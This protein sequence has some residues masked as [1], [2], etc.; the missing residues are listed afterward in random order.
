MTDFEIYFAEINYSFPMI[1]VK[2]T[3]DTSYLFGEEEKINIRLRDFYL[4]K[5]PVT[6]KLW[7]YIAGIN[8]SHFNGKDRPVECVSFNDITGKNGF[9]DRLNASNGKRYQ[10]NK[11]LGF[12]LPSETEWEYAARGGI[13]WM[14]DFQF[15][16][17]NDLNAVGWFEQNSGK[18]TDLAALRQ[19]KNQ[20][21]GTETHGVGQKSANQLGTF[22]MCGNVWEWCQDYFQRDINKIPKD[23]S[24][25]LLE[26]RDRVL[27]G[28]CH[29]NRAI[30][31][32]VSKRYEIS[33][34]S[35]DECIGFRIAASA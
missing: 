28:G 11:N 25:C 7:E 10:S 34:E 16:G 2:G 29:H 32:T 26:S 5:Y 13:H 17:S 20:D 9:L 19:L 15:S 14:D 8:P 35:K 27:R 6:Q 30:H 18:I 4:S 3:K 1:F 21:K 24:P 23:G 12:R 22:D 31:C 33:P